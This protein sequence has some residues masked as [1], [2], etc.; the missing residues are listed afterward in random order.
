M[1]HAARAREPRLD[2]RRR[3]RRAVAVHESAARQGRGD[4]D[5]D[6]GASQLVG[7]DASRPQAE[8]ARGKPGRAREQGEALDGA[9]HAADAE[10]LDDVYDLRAQRLSVHQ[11]P[12]RVKLLSRI[13]QETGGKCHYTKVEMMR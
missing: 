3:P 5:A 2:P 8:H 12:R 4:V 10:V 6:P 1:D 7:D 11:K 9:L 13:G